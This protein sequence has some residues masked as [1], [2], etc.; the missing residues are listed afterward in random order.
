M[1][2]AVLAVP[3]FGES[4]GGNA[5][6]V[7]G[8]EAPIAAVEISFFFAF[9]AV[10]VIEFVDIGYFLLLHN[11]AFLGGNRV[12]DLG[13]GVV[14]LNYHIFIIAAS[15]C[16]QNFPA[17]NFQNRILLEVSQ[18]RTGQM[19]GEVKG[20]GKSVIEIKYMIWRSIHHTI[21]TFE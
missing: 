4:F 6:F 13:V 14:A 15:R 20:K 19:G 18:K 21:H 8:A 5:G 9:E 10:V 7:E 12:L 1:A 2:V 16:S 11:Y 3:D 17:S